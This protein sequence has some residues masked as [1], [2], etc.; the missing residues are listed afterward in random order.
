M[1]IVIAVVEASHYL[2]YQ[3]SSSYK[4]ITPFVI[5][6]MVLKMSLKCRFLKASILFVLNPHDI[7]NAIPCCDKHLTYICIWYGIIFS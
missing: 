5:C 7:G 2:A 1:G 6:I 4:E 3:T